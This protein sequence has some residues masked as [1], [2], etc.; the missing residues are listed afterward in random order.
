MH[1]AMPRFHCDTGLK[2]PV[3]DNV[4]ELYQCIYYVGYTVRTKWGPIIIQIEY[5][6]HI[7]PECIDFKDYR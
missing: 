3:N 2:I 6:L 7:T 5:E 4:A 1:C